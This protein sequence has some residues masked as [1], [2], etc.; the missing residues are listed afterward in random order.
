MHYDTETLHI[1]QTDDIVYSIFESQI[2]YIDQC[3]GFSF[4]PGR[5]AVIFTCSQTCSEVYCYISQ[6]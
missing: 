1:L 5:Y 4:I 2:D 6:A 3:T